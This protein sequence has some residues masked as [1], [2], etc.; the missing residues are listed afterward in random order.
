MNNPISFMSANFVARQLNYQMT[1]GWGQGD[2]ATNAYFQPIESFGERFAAL[3]AEVQAMGFT[4]ID[5]WTAHL[6]P[7]WATPEHIA[8]SQALL[9]QYGL[10]VTSLAGG[11]GA[12][13]EEVTASCRL[14]QALGTTI[15]GGNSGLLVTDRPL[16][17]GI[18]RD[19]GVRL[20]IENHPEK[21]P[22]EL[23]A[24]LDDGDDGVIGACVDTGWFGTQGFDAAFA[25]VEL[26][27]HLVH[28]H[29]K[30]V[31]AVGAHETCRYGRGVVPI[32]LCVET[33]IRIGY[34]GPIS[35]EHEPERADP[36]TDCKNN[37]RML[38]RWFLA[39][40]A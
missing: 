25:L 40:S 10:T 5:L 7:R 14:A 15:L 38:Q 18:L 27:N 1:E 36:T 11:F 33:L 20:G 22:Q 35:V 29:L 8:T 21:T 17:V 19:H 16:L 9:A 31:L 24:K 13:R 2:R 4:A 23:L 34:S 28:V 30:D 32:K 12:T 6:N 26:R 3:L 37:L 39:W